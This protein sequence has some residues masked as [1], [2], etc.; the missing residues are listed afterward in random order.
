MYGYFIK[1]A[2]RA[3]Y[4]YMESNSTH[5]HTLGWS[6]DFPLR[7]TEHSKKGLERML[8][9]RDTEKRSEMSLGSD[10]TMASV[11]SQQL[12]L[13]AWDLHKTEPINSQDGVMG[14]HTRCWII[15]TWWVLGERQS[16]CLHCLQVCAKWWVAQKKKK[17]HKY[18]GK[19]NKFPW[20]CG[21]I[22]MDRTIN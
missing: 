19:N 1:L 10:T 21:Q 9:L 16:L 8:V 3:F 18:L 5:G 15:G 13:P 17:R 7:L 11:T 4:G 6:F 2:P 12:W 22:T 20:Q 14:L